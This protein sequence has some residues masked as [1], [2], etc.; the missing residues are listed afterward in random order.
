MVK[1]IQFTRRG[2]K[3]PRSYHEPLTS[4]TK[5]ESKIR[6]RIK[7]HYTNLTLKEMLVLAAGIIG[8]AAI[9]NR[10]NQSWFPSRRG[11]QMV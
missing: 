3:F 8:V 5:R 4:N 2:Q 9:R 7:V 6:I 1:Y 10:K 11:F